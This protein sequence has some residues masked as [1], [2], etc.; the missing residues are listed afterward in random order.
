MRYRSLAII[1]LLSAA[2]ALP[3]CAQLREWFGGDNSDTAKTVI[4]VA[5][6]KY[7][8]DDTDRADRVY[9]ITTG[10]IDQVNAG[11]EST[12]DAVEA[13]VRAEI[14]WDR[15]D[16]AETL[17]ADRLIVAVR[18]E[19]ESK[20]EDGVLAPDDRVLVADVLGWI[21]DAAVMAGAGGAT[22]DANQHETMAGREA[23][24]GRR[25]PGSQVVA[26][27]GT[28]PRARAPA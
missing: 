19:I 7:I 18:T 15:L 9:Q 25:A 5:V 24:L 2:I 1:G 14:R 6:L 10:A 3:G 4:Q 11:T 16:S 28:Q 21:R 27:I 8:G 20:I 22:A 17:I 26:S 23:A 12:L 13:Y